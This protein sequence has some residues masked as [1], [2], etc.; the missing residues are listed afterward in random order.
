MPLSLEPECVARQ[1]VDLSQSDGRGFG[2]QL[3]RVD[4]RPIEP[5]QL[6][7]DVRDVLVRDPRSREITT[8]LHERFGAVG[9]RGRVGLHRVETR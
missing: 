5:D 7:E 4:V 6:S 2:Q 3:L 1:L 9:H 8:E